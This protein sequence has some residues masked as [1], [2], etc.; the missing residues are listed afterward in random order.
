M[1]SPLISIKNGEIIFENRLIFEN[2]NLTIDKGKCVA[3]TGHNSSGKSVILKALAGKSVLSSGEII[4]TYKNKEIFKKNEDE[5]SVYNNIGYLDVRHKFKDRQ[6]QNTFFY[7]Q[8]YNSSFSEESPTSIEFMYNAQKESVKNGYWDIKKVVDILNLEN[9]LDKNLIKLSNGESRRVRIA[10]ILIKNPLLIF[11]DQP[12]TGVDVENRLQF[13]SVFKAITNS[14]IALVIACN[15]DEVPNISHTVVKLNIGNSPTITDYKNYKPHIEKQISSINEEHIAFLKKMPPHEKYEWIV[16]MSDVNIKNDDKQILNDINWQIKQ[17][18]R[19]S[20]Y[21][22]NGAGKST[23]LSLITGDNPQAYSNDIILF[24][25]KRGSGES[26]WDIKRKIG[27]VSPELFQFFPQHLTCKEAI[28]TGFSDF[29]IKQKKISEQQ[30]SVIDRWMSILKISEF[31]DTILRKLPI[32][33]QRLI[34]LARALVKN[35]PLLILDEPC[36]GFD[37]HQQ[38]HFRDI[39]DIISNFT[40]IT[41]IYVT[42]KKEQLP[43][44]VT[45]YLFLTKSGE[46]DNSEK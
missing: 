5:I 17:G 27:F 33:T 28:S 2:L 25:I 9:L 20:L 23:L 4:R 26:I 10:E 36:Q 31:K 44:S 39:I 30:N 40:N 43:K 8:R 14:G 38:S 12:F 46:R 7:Q 11:L 41:W 6:N 29:F 18:E 21:G 22:A 45:D 1:S 19:W 37:N 34:L 15:E 42:H 35:P 16:K 13:N 32:T 24:D 3:I